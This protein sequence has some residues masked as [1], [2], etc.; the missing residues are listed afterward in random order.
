MAKKVVKGHSLAGFATR[1]ISSL[2]A[3]YY[4]PFEILARPSVRPLRPDFA[5]FAI[6]AIF[7]KMAIF[8]DFP[9]F[10]IF[11][12]FTIFRIFQHFSRF[13]RKPG[14]S[15]F[16]GIPDISGPDFPKIRARAGESGNR[17]QKISQKVAT[18]HFTH[19]FLCDLCFI[20]QLFFKIFLYF[21]R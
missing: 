16:S 1:P 4:S 20:S 15:G 18:E 2:W 5:F 13:L 12:F 7:R 17:V 21:C 19:V 10:T 9:D 14:I 11:T 3:S 6:F 8:H